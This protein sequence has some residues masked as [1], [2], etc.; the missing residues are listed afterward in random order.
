MRHHRISAE[1]GVLAGRAGVGL[2]PQHYRTII[3]TA[4]Q[5]GFFEVHAE[6]YMGEGGPP[7]RWLEQIRNR[8]P[9]SLH[10]VGLSIG[11]S[12]P[13]DRR[14]LGRLKSLIGRYSPQLFSEH[15]AWSS[16]DGVFYNDLLPLPYTTATL[17]RVSEHIHQVQ[18]TLGQRMLLENPSSYVSFDESSLSETDFIREVQQR[19]GCGLLLDVNNVVV[20]SANLGWDPFAYVRA[21]PLEQVEEIHLAGHKREADEHGDP[22]LIDTHD[23][24]VGDDA[25]RL[26]R[27]AIE[28]AGPIATLIEWDVNI[29]SWEALHNEAVR[30]ESIMRAADYSGASGAASAA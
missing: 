25:W 30:A 9:L 28:L 23:R 6:N 19:T 26:Y 2:K 11:G 27:T 21:F 5:V 4:P 16:H 20:A 10:G 1:T 14:H 18:E 7:H 8:Y 24:P 3:E 12:Q 15:L 17:R 22:L 29:P 13:L